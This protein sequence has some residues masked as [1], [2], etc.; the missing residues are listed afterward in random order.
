MR[1]VGLL[2]VF[3]N[4]G[5][6]ADRLDSIIKKNVT[7]IVVLLLGFKLQDQVQIVR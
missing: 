6:I 2:I 4:L 3:S 7:R 5:S 1:I